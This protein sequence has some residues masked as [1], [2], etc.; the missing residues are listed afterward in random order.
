[1]DAESRK[2]PSL[3]LSPAIGLVGLLVT[4]VW[5]YLQMRHWRQ[6]D[7]DYL[8]IATTLT[9]TAVLWATLLFAIIMNLREAKKAREKVAPAKSKI[10]LP[11]K[12]SILFETAGAGLGL[13][14][15]DKWA[16]AGSFDVL[17]LEAEKLKTF[18]ED[19]R[20]ADV[21]KK[22]SRPLSLNA[23][24]D[25]ITDWSDKQLLEFRIL[26]RS[27]LEKMKRLHYGLQTVLT[28]IGFPSETRS[29]D[30]LRLLSEHLENLRDAK[31]DCIAKA[32][33]TAC[34]GIRTVLAG[35]N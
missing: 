5:A 31:A 10:E 16:D 18:F 30:V 13:S 34:V 19:I 33:P 27:H 2:G 35:G 1:M 21:G 14:A 28:M 29:L 24:P 11:D 4:V 12:A 3:W 25:T 8:A 22:Y 26:L 23:L 9:I 20:E 7:A 6:P 17:I 15:A 32:W